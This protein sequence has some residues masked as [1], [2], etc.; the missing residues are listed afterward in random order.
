M[1]TWLSQQFEAGG[2]ML[3]LASNLPVEKVDLGRRDSLNEA[4]LTTLIKRKEMQDGS[5]RNYTYKEKFR[6]ESQQ[7]KKLLPF[8]WDDQAGHNRALVRWE[9]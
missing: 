5:W 7:A 4:E 8:V 9:P 2:R 3:Y 6:A 1:G